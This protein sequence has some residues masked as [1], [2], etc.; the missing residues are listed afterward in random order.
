M[1]KISVLVPVFNEEEN[2]VNT[3]NALKQL[4]EDVKSRYDHEIIF[5]DNHS[6][7][8]TF[9]LLQT[10]AH[11][12]KRL[13]AVSFSKNFGYQRSI[14]TA[15]L[16]SSGDAVIQIDC[17]LQ[18]PPSMITEFIKK[19]EEGYAVV[20]GIRKCRRE[21]WLMN[22]IRKLFYRLIAFLSE[23]NL[24]YDAG[25]FRLVDKKIVD[26][27]RKINDCSPY[28]RGLIASFGFEQIGI[29]YERAKRKKG[30]S[31][32]KFIELLELAMDGIA[33]H[34]IIPLRLA[35]YFGLCTFI[36]AFSLLLLSVIGRVFFTQYFPRGFAT[37]TV[38]ILFSL[39]LNA[40]FLGIIG[41]YIGRMY[42]QVKSHP[43]AIIDKM[44]N[45]EFGNK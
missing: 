39:G 10:L 27:L 45:F 12:D 35:T 31:K 25:D 18:D 38:L 41:E 34:S 40:F 30:K 23:D 36:S 32:F 15:Y 24:P 9:T 37:T 21:F 22:I 5:T 28:I 33:N 7:D 44:I 29:P 11:T 2:V 20:Y 42:K 13:K 17:D 8:K 16:L 19:W 6:T 4:L 14:Y 1:K 43:I 26:E 3:Y